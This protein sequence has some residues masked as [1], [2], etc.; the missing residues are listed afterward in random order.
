MRSNERGRVRLLT[1][2]CMAVL[3]VASIFV[4]GCL[5][6]HDRGHDHEHD[7]DHVEHHEGDH[8]H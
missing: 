6:D 3:F 1:S 4:G 2:I 5:D 8:D 7:R